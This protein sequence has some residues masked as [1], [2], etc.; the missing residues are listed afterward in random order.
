[1]TKRMAVWTAL[2]LGLVWGSAPT[3][4]LAG[5]W[6][7]VQRKGVVVVGVTDQEPPFGY[8]EDD[9]GR[10]V[11]YD[12]DYMTA[13]AARWGVRALFKVVTPADRLGALL[14]GDIDVIAAGLSHSDARAA[15]LGFSAPYLV[16][17]QKVIARRGV[18]RSLEDLEGK[19]MGAVIGTFAESC[20]RDRCRITRV[21]PFDTY[22]DG[23]EALQN[24]KIEAF[25]ADEAILVDLFSALPGNGYEIPDVTILQEEYNLAVRSG[26]TAFL[27]QLD[28]TIAAIQEDGEAARIRRAWYGTPEEL[29]PPAY[30]SVVRKAS[31][32]PRFL[33]VVLSGVLVPDAEVDIRSP[34]GR[35]VGRGRISSVISDEFYLDADPA[36]YDLVLPGFLVTMNMN[37][38]MAMDVLMRRKEVLDGVAAKARVAEAELTSR[39][40]EEAL[41]KQQRARE[42]DTI[43]HQ[44]K[45]S[46]QSDR[47]RYNSYYGRRSLRR[48]YRY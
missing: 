4:A 5:T 11:G 29:A 15:V 19:R 14:D 13:V 44:A 41:A 39:I 42:M 20:A 21:V 26:D 18:V 32:R 48:G 43:R 22:V 2:V 27:A 6:E 1:M 37:T 28:Q 47:A 45:V 8:R 38:Q 31:T 17:G 16:S 30:G 9:S 34:D 12:I 33:G 3:L 7:E 23:L 36:V 35:E 46:A 25:T 24:G 40:N 10:L